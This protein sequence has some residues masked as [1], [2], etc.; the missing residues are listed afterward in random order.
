M[1][2]DSSLHENAVQAVAR[3]EGSPPKR[4]RRKVERHPATT[5]KSVK[6]DA[7]VMKEARKRAAG[8]FV[9]LIEGPDS[10]LIT[11]QERTRNFS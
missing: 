2:K 7:R 1:G 8:R 10:V 11:N 4:K 6:V 5:Y 3:G 9:I